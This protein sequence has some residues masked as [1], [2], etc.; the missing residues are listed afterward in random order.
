MP[1]TGIQLR[2]KLSTKLSSPTTR[3]RLYPLPRLERDYT[4][5]TDLLA[6]DELYPF[7]LSNN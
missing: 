4:E 1:D 6:A 5:G 2:T 3:T 7:T